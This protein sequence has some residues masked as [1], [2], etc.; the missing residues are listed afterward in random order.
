MQ[1]STTFT[2]D[3]ECTA[4]TY[5]DHS[6]QP[7]TLRR[8]SPL[9]TITQRISVTVYASLDRAPPQRRVLPCRYESLRRD[10]TAQFASDQYITMRH[11]VS[12]LNIT[13]R[14]DNTLQN[15]TIRYDE[16]V[17]GVPIQNTSTDH[18]PSLS[19]CTICSMTTNLAKPNLIFPVRNDNS[20]QPNSFQNIVTGPPGLRRFGTTLVDESYLADTNLY[21]ESDRA[22]SNLNNET[23]RQ[24]FT[25]RNTSARL[26]MPRRIEPPQYDSPRSARLSLA[27]TTLHAATLLHMTKWLAHSSRITTTNWLLTTLAMTTYYTASNRYDFTC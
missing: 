4:A 27:G 3:L 11:D 8:H 26:V 13:W 7:N 23:I 6:W 14:Y 18:V 21:D 17:H 10:G 22:V 20:E 9:Q 2:D 15:A 1:A 25:Y 16:S 19:I 12:A 24:Y 5:R